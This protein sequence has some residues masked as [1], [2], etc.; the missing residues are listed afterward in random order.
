MVVANLPYNIATTL[1][2]TWLRQPER[3][4]RPPK[5]TSTVIEIVPRP[6]PAMAVP[7]V[8][9][10]RLTAAAFGQ[11]RKMLRSSLRQ[12]GPDPERHLRAAGIDPTARAETLDVEDFCR[13]A[14]T[15]GRES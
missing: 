14:L 13:L 12:L 4:A 1:L 8:D 6:E 7:R 9:L 2:L 11:R 10:E 15:Y 3:F 5:V